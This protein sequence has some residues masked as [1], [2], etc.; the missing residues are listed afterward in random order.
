MLNPANFGELDRR[1]K[2]K[3]PAVDLF[4]G[5]SVGLVSMKSLLIAG[6]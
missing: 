1:N 4:V 6:Q 2:V 3:N 5:V